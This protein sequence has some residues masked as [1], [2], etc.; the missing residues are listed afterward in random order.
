[1]DSFFKKTILKIINDIFGLYYKLVYIYDIF[2][3]IISLI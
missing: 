2:T 3:F 1:M